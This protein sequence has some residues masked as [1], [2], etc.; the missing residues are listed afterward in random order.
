MPVGGPYVGF[1]L[2]IT[3]T[4]EIRR[5]TVGANWIEQIKRNSKPIDELPQPI[6][7]GDQTLQ[8]QV[9]N[10]DDII[11][12]SG[13]DSNE[14]FEPPVPNAITKLDLSSQLERQSFLES[15]GLDPQLIVYGDRIVLTASYATTGVFPNGYLFKSYLPEAGPKLSDQAIYEQSKKINY[16]ANNDGKIDIM[17]TWNVNGIDYFEAQLLPSSYIQNIGR[18]IE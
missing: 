16:D 15:N 11:Y 1:K 14:E 8:Q 12:D 2:H 7:I 10:N 9:K 5:N 17:D 4:Q 18:K 6:P 13:D 3:S